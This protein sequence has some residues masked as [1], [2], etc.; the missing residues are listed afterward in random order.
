MSWSTVFRNRNNSVIHLP[1]SL[2]FLPR[3]FTWAAVGGPELA[4]IS[5]NGSLLDLWQLLDWLCYPV[6]L[7]NPLQ[8]VV[9]WGYVEEVSITVGAI[10]LGVSLNTMHNRIAVAYSYVEPGT[11][12]VGTRRTTDWVQDDYAV[13]VYGIKEH[14]ASVDGATTTQAENTRDILLA[15]HRFPIPVVDISDSEQIEAQ[16]FCRGWWDTLRWRYYANGATNSVETTTQ[17]A[18]IVNNVGEFLTGA[19]V[20]N[21]S[22]IHTSE[23]RDGDSTAQEVIREL[24]RTGIAG[25][26]RLLATVTYP[27]TLQVYAE[28]QSTPVN[29]FLTVDGRIVTRVGE[30]LASDVMPVGKW[31]G[32]KDILPGTLPAYLA[33]PSPFFVEH[34]EYDIEQGRWLPI[35]RGVPSPW[36]V[37]RIVEG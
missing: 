4:E 7:R 19:D 21:A 20:M 27:R 25:G 9:W 11:Q 10:K 16:L 8:Q 13:S 6:E 12:E 28:P 32:L 15:Q 29:L 26:Q 36:D 34:S 1:P 5:V 17:I 23:Y 33:N 3:H 22:G 31:I 30:P 18:T 37:T 2:R 24:L 14:L 35:P